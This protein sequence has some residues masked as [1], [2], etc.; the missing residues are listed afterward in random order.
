MSNYHLQQI[1]IVFVRNFM[2]FLTCYLTNA[3][4]PLFTF[5]TVTCEEKSTYLALDQSV[6]NQ[7]IKLFT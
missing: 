4:T 1:K 5:S 3:S 2:V 6:V 7:F